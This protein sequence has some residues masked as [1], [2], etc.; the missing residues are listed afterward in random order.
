MQ[1]DAVG[2]AGRAMSGVCWASPHRRPETDSSR[3][4]APESEPNSDGVCVG[5][6]NG[7]AIG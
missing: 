1:V 3:S 6:G 4:V 7:R 5:V 2:R